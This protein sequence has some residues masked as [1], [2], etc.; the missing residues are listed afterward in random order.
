MHPFELFEAHGEVEFDVGCCVGVV[1]QLDV[2]VEPVHA[3]AKPQGFVPFEAGLLP[4]FVPLFLGAGLDEKLHFHLFKFPHAEN[5]LPGDDFIS[6]G[7]SNLRNAKR[8]LHTAAFLDVE[9]IDEDP[10]GGFGP[11]V[12]HTAVPAHGTQFCFEHEVELPHVGPISAAGVR[13]GNPQV[14]DQGL[15]RR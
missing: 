7:L 11:Q 12:D 10:L 6:E 8:Q 4:V 2:I 15:D 13:V 9:V 3:F 5:K 14:F 1:R